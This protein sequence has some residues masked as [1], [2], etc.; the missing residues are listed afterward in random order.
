ML[1]DRS[2]ESA[3]SIDFGAGLK[4]LKGAVDDRIVH[5][6]RSKRLLEDVLVMIRPHDF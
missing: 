3:I 5:L 2:G 4:K 6:Y 1:N